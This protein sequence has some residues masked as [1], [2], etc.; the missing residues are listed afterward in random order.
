MKKSQSFL[1]VYPYW[2]KW[3]GAASILFGLIVFLYRVLHYEIVDIRGGSFP[4][5][6]GLT[7]IFFSREKTFD[8][9]IVFLKFK[10]L[11][12]AVPLAVAITM[13]INYSYNFEGYSIETDSWFSISAFE[14]LTIALLVALGWFHYLRIK[15]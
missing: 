7:L 10:A 1:F 6:I 9:R 2:A 4:V 14:Y 5:A 12:M 13:L 3:L 15:A 11:A 8:E